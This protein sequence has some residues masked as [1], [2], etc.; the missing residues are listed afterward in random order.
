MK[1]F[2][3]FLPLLAVVALVAGGVAFF[4]S[5]PKTVPVVTPEKRTVVESIAAAGRV[6]GQVETSVG[7][8]TG[9]RVAEVPV[10]EGDRVN[11]G[12]VLARLDDTVLQA[13]A[14]QA[15]DA[16]RTAD[17]QRLQAVDSART[18]RFQYAQATDAVDT[19]KAQYEQAARPPL[20]SDVDR[21]KAEVAQNVA[22][23]EAKL[24]AAKQKLAELRE[25]ATREDRLALDAQVEQARA[26]VEQAEREYARQ[27]TLLKEG[28]VAQ[29]VAENAETSL[30]VAKRTLENLLAQQKKQT[31]GTRPEQLAQA[32]ADVRAAEAGVTGAKATGAAQLRTLLATPRPEDVAVAR[33]RVDEARRAREV[34]S[35]RVRE[36]DRAREIAD[37]RV[38]EARESLRVAESRLGDAFVRAPFAGTVTQIVTEA[39][40]V[41]GPNQPVVR[42]V[43]WSTPEI[44][45]DVD[46][47]YLGKIKRKQE[48]VVTSDAFP[49]EKFRATIREIGAQVDADRGTVEVRLDPTDAPDWLRPGQTVS[50]NIIVDAGTERLV[51]PL[52][53]VTT[54]GGAS[55]VLVVENG[56][57]A[58]REVTVGAP[59]PDGIPILSGV[60]EG[61]QVA[62]NPTGLSTGTKV[63]VAWV[64]IKLGKGK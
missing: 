11:E 22:V 29:S 7:A 35:A 56:A 47:N 15:R 14:R 6:R 12:E 59:G 50:V 23:A 49:G 43:R 28:A 48:A 25:G 24:A 33:R 26:N 55:S 36:A 32:E 20:K 5:R 16:V 27:S 38:A 2:L 10:R 34:A 60:R 18:A 51:L 40:G 44:R 45:I 31:V 3:R 1:T 57:I 62:A 63:V 58:R 8:Q 61:D 41:T 4:Q 9:G 17:I 13:Q 52:T 42:L 19:A 64:R 37:S 30:K 39:G 54:I 21:L 46:E 53:A